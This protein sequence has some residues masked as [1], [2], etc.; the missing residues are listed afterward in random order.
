MRKLAHI[1]VTVWLVMLWSSCL[2]SQSQPERY[3]QNII[4]EGSF[5]KK[6][7]L[8][9]QL[10][11]LGA[12]E[13]RSLLLKLLDDSHY[14]NRCAAIQGLWFYDEP[15]VKR[16]LIKKLMDDHM[17]RDEIAAGLKTRMPKFAAA[18]AEEYNRETDAEKRKI[19]LTCVA[20]T[21]SKE[22]EDFLKGIVAD[23]TS[24]DRRLAAG[25]IARSFP[26]N[27]QLFIGLVDDPEVRIVA[28]G[29]LAE[30]G[31]V[32][33]L[34]LFASILEREAE[35]A[36]KVVAYQAVAKWGDA[37]LRERT[38]LNALSSGNEVLVRGGLAAFRSLYNPEI[39]AQLGSLTSQAREQ[40]TR[41]A[42]GVRL[43]EL[44]RSEAVPYLV[45]LLDEEYREQK[46][47][48]F[49][50]IASVMTAGIW[51]VLEGLSQGFSRKNYENSRAAIL[52]GL[53]RITGADAG[54]E[55][56]SWKEWSILHGYV[57][58]GEN[59]VQRL[60]SS[61]PEK[62]RAAAGAAAVLLGYKSLGDFIEKKRLTD[63]ER[64]LILALARELMDRG[65]LE[66]KK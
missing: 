28:L 15:E 20:A 57:I 52:A 2:F 63:S 64:D 43:A 53:R 51:M 32:R 38:Y 21:G 4:Q 50:A 41:M 61:N 66:E 14:W 39:S 54:P 10:G 34:P 56:E 5:Q 29:F 13:A 60:F 16:R 22:A 3:Y 47:A 23:R 18:A 59:I 8:G 26:D 30:N 58:Q 37:A 9:R 11:R 44:G 45:P 12:A 36:E 17:V 1:L 46:S 24:P 65:F 35:E 42:A 7:E 40:R 48:T 25:Q 31:S 19:L 33:D 55:Y 62:R 6:R 27:Y 49:D